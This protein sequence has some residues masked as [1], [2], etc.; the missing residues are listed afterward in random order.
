M[1]RP[2]ASLDLS[3]RSFLKTSINTAVKGK[4]EVKVSNHLLQF[5]HTLDDISPSMFVVYLLIFKLLSINVE[6]V[7]T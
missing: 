7:G 6:S 1:P 5:L 4:A 3:G 2:R